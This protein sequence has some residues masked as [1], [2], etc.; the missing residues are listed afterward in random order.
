MNCHALFFASSLVLATAVFAQAPKIDFPAASPACT[1]KQRVGLTDIE[2]TY[3]RPSAKGR[4]M[5]GGIDPYGEVWRTGANDATKIVFSTPVKLNGAEV[6]AGTYGLFTI[7][8]QKEWTIILSK[9]SKQ[10]GAYK[11]DAKDD[12]VRFKATPAPLPEPV[13]SFTIDFSNFTMG[14]ASLD[15]SWEKVQVPIEVRGDVSPVVAQ[16]DAVMAGEGKKPYVKAAQ[17]YYDAGLDPKKALAWVDAA[18]AETPATFSVATL[19]TKL[20]AQAGEKDAAIEQA[21]PRNFSATSS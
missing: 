20:L 18:I 9:I 17:F 5:L 1:I 19:R 2:I 3:S 16:I 11:Y 14:Q 6:A 8:G 21:Q 12:V 4:K 7:P 13:E 10:W 15:L